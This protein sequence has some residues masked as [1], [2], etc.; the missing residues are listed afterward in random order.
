MKPD[1]KLAFKISGK[2]FI[3]T[4]EYLPG[5]RYRVND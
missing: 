1:S 5:C 2:E 3:V 4:A